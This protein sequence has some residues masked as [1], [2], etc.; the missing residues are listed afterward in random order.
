MTTN[1]GVI[2]CGSIQFL[3]LMKTNGKDLGC[4][5][6]R[7]NSSDICPIVQHLTIYQDE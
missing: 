6:D 5:F 3:I 2:V 7:L 1:F 4:Y